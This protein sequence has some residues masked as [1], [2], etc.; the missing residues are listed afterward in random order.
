MRGWLLRLYR[1]LRPD[2]SERELDEELRHHVDL[3]T[4]ALV[5]S[6]L[7]PEEARRRALIAFGGEDRWREEMRAA[8]GTLWI[9]DGLRD[10]RFA[11][12]ALGRTPAFT[13]SVLATLTLAVGA[14]TAIYSVVRGV[15]LAP[16]PFPEADRLVTVWMSNPAQG[17]E[18]DITSW[19]NFTDWRARSTTIDPMVA[20]R[21]QRWTLTGDDGDPEEVSGAA[22]STGFFDLLATPL[23]I[24]RAFRDEEAEGDPSGVVVLSHELWTRR[25]GADP[26]IVGSTIRLNDGPW[27]V[28]GV[29]A[30]GRRYPPGAE[31]WTP[32]TF[33]PQLEGLRE[34]RG[35]LWLPV[36]GRLTDGV[37]L[38]AAQSEMNGVAGTLR[39]EYPGVNDGVGITLEPLQTTLVGDV[40][41]PL[42]VLLGAVALVLLIAVVNVANLLLVRGISRGRE[43]ALRLTLGAGRSRVVRQ[44]LTESFVLGGI[45]GL[46]GA[47][48]AVLGVEALIR[49]APPGLPRIDE[50]TIEPV[51]LLSA[52]A[53]ALGASLFFGLAPALHAAGVDVTGQISEGSAR[54]GSSGRLAKAR[55]VF[56]TGQFA[57]ALVLL[58]GTGLLLRSF[59]NLRA[60]DP[61]FE[62]GGVLMAS[63]ALPGARY[64]DAQALRGFTDELFPAL[65]AIPG[66][67]RAGSV[68]TLFLSALPNMGSIVVES[69]PELD[70]T[71]QEHPVVGDPASDGFLQAVGMRLIA[72]R[73]VTPADGPDETPVAVVNETFVRTF[74]SDRDP[75]GERFT[76]NARNADDPGWVT[77]VGVVA[78]ARRSGL[79][80]AVRPSAFLAHRQ[81]PVRRFDVFLR[82]S[83]DPAS[84]APALRS[85]VGAIDP[86]LPLTRMRTLDQAMSES[87]SVRRFIVVLL[88]VFAAAALALAAV[89]IYG[90]MA[91]VVGQR[92]RE[93]GVRVA[94]GAERGTILGRVLGEGLLHAVAGMV[95]GGVGAL[96]L[97]RYVRTLL[98]GLE[99]ADPATFALATVLLLLVACAASALPALRASTID[100]M[101][102]LREE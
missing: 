57:L 72:G 25:F 78:D 6:G 43:L 75:L 46:G 74:L 40:R 93:I 24:G 4:D 17:I 94:L 87:L 32:L 89:G 45:G 39:E 56:V 99:P 61:G 27:E 97:T 31:L 59:A 65:E 18:E 73:G 44:A 81:A 68:S 37:E 96:L 5:R 64:P 69:R 85:A 52:M 66:V 58:V 98:F 33:G 42:L 13:L 28:V 16:L 70:A 83:G 15:V 53:V 10:L 86:M 41:T 77:I 9:E 29:T 54:S 12:R 48:V 30:P 102:A 62:P 47:A 91:Y 55:G 76:W 21:G 67:A 63:L 51:L 20:V 49:L 88:S 100:P 7:D 79:D 34:A 71:A 22:V 11:L 82:A 14:T 8:R 60:V 23:L 3:E 2:A 35:A 95:L 80:A 50:V 92:T 101:V 84:L 90:V 36:V 1:L 38:E 26:G 19:P